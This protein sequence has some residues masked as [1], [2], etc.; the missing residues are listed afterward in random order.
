MK[1]ADQLHQLTT[2]TPFQVGSVNAYLIEDNPLTLID[3]GL[4]TPEAEASLRAQ[5]ADLGVRFGDIEQI[6]VTHSHLDHY[7]LMGKIAAEGRPRVFAHPLEVH[8]L[9]SLH[10]YSEEDDLYKRVE[11]FLLKSGLPTESLDSILMRH[12]IINDLRDPIKV[13][14]M[15]DDGDVIG[16]AHKEL[17]VVHCPGHSAGMINLYDAGAK[18]LFSGDNLLKHISPVPLLNFPRDP[19]RPRSHSLSEYIATLQRLKT[20][21]IAIVLTGHGEVIYDAVEVIDSIIRHHKVRKDK[22][23]KFLEGF[24]KTAFDVCKHLFP[25]ITPYQ[26]YLGMSE[27]VGHLDVL[28][29]EGAIG[30]IEE[31]GMTRFRPL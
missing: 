8:D 13:T 9:E 26:V 24:P 5:L 1:L 27:A 22:V 17:L 14:E 7:G 21:D 10:G 23:L 29:T 6:I 30:R 31:N 20:F 15:V 11:S 16:L 2:P 28:E 4:K 25:D 12:P 3:S 19:S 18:V